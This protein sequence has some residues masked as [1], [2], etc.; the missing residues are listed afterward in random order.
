MT[1][2]VYLALAMAVLAAHLLFNLWV[3]SEAGVTR[4]RPKLA[5]PNIGSVVYGTVMENAP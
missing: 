5:E 1:A 3:V 4:A 2:D